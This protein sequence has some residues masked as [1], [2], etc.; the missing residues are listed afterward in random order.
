MQQQSADQQPTIIIYGTPW[1]S[2]CHRSRRFLESKSIPY[3]YVD[4][5]D[6]PEAIA[7]VERVNNGQ[8][9]VPTMV[10]PD[11]S[12]LVEPSNKALASKLGL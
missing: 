1:C 5:S 9:S 6:N 10:F 4:I 11:G 12:V 2:D 7:T 8:Q 3:Q